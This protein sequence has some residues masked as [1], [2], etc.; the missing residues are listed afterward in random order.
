MDNKIKVGDTI[1]VE[2]AWEDDAGAY[3]DEEAEVLSIDNKGDMQLKFRNVPITRMLLSAEWNVKDFQNCVIEKGYKNNKNKYYIKRLEKRISGMEDYL[4]ELAHPA[5]KN[6]LNTFKPDYL[7][8]TLIL[9]VAHLT[10]DVEK[11][12]E[13]R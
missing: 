1:E 12:K 6:K 2:Q 3:H 10:R 9:Q 5:Y 7:L 4:M 8:S 13:M 11:L